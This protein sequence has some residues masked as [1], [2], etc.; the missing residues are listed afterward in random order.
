MAALQKQLQAPLPPPSDE[1]N[2]FRNPFG[3]LIMLEVNEPDK[4]GSCRSINHERGH[5]N[6]TKYTKP[7]RGR[8]ANPGNSVNTAFQNPL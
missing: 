7:Q 3:M 4:N 6:T 8:E 1:E 5:T 2:G